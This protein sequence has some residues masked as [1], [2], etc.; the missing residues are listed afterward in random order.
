[1]FNTRVPTRPLL[2]RAAG[3]LAVF[4]LGLVMFT[5]LDHRLWE[6]FLRGDEI[7]NRDWY[8]FLRNAGYLPTWIVVAAALVLAGHQAGGRRPS[9]FAAVALAPAAAGLAA[10][11]LKIIVSRDRPGATGLHHYRGLFAGFSD[12]SNLGMPSSHAAVAFAAAF[13]LL[14]LAPPGGW[15]V[16]PV[17]AGCGLTRLLMGDHFTSDIYVAAWLGWLAARLFVPRPSTRI[18]LVHTRTTIHG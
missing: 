4:A 9:R 10:E 14:R 6:F 5:L 2:L 17:A 18:G 3:L 13:T 16:L 7:K 8:I 15:V 1:M 11:L 12:G